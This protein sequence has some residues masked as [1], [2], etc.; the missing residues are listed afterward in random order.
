M[1]D[2]IKP[3]KAPKGWA[4]WQ[5]ILARKGLKLDRGKIKPKT[6]TPRQRAI[7]K[8]NL[9]RPSIGP[10]PV[11]VN[12]KPS[13]QSATGGQQTPGSRSTPEQAQKP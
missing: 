5:A 12:Q 9:E 11:R 2:P 1:P 6:M 4:K 8:H 13:I 3:W 10:G 7:L